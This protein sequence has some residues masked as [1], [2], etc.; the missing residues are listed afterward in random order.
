MAGKYCN[1]SKLQVVSV[2]KPVN[3]YMYYVDGYRPVKK[4]SSDKIRVFQYI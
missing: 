2:T 1:S 3:K 4:A